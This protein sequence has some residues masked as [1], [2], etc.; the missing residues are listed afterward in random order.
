MGHIIS[1]NGVVTDPKKVEAMLSW[2]IPKNI[3]ALRGF[4]GLTGY[5][6]KFVKSYGEIS[7]PLTN[8]LKKNK[9]SWNE[10]ATL[11]FEQLKAATSS[12][13]V[14]ALPNFNKPFIVETDASQSGIGVVL[15]HENRPIAYI[16]KTLPPTKHALSTYEKELWAL[17]YAVHKWRPYLLGHQFIIRTDH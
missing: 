6:R 1:A 11:A 15:M 3:K 9:F 10:A 17:V 14:L 7:R 5:Y 16:S 4:L 2:P 13:P 12:T 8:L